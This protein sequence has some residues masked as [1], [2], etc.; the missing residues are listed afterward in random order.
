MIK[1]SKNGLNNHSSSYLEDQ[2]DQKGI[3]HYKLDRE[4]RTTMVY[5]E[6]W[7]K[8]LTLVSQFLCLFLEYQ[9]DKKNCKLSEFLILIIRYD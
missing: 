3:L 8:I 9:R 5:I 2:E 7:G 1:N 4:N 6:N